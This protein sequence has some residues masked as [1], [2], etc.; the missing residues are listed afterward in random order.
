MN[1]APC[2]LC[3]VI[4][5]IGLKHLVNFK[6]TVINPKWYKTYS[7]HPG[8]AEG[9]RELLVEGFK[10]IKGNASYKTYKYPMKPIEVHAYFGEY[11]DE[12][13]DEFDKINT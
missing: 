5:Y 7:P 3:A 11:R 8:P 1:V 2:A 10:G 13:W 6:S 4:A 12:S 9:L